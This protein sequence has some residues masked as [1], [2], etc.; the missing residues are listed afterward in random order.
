MAEQAKSNTGA[1]EDSRVQ[2][3]IAEF[4]SLLVPEETMDAYAV[5]RRIFALAHRRLLVCATSGR[6]IGMSRGL[7]GGFRPDTVRWQDIKD[8]NIRVGMLGA[9][10]TISALATPDLAVAGQTRVLSF[11]G[12][13]KNQAEAVYR[14]CQAQEQ[15]WREKRRVRELEELRA[16]SGGMQ[17]GT[18]TGEIIG[19]ARTVAGDS[20]AA[21]LAQAKQMF[22]QK[23]IT[24]SEYESL[25]ARIVGSL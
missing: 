24:D 20:A 12:L 22:D 8:V 9:D 17:L 1:G 21:R 19:A 16:K 7:F 10:L 2:R 23:L 4:Q 13:R 3:G 14:I 15:A 5:Q 6:F 18:P 11:P 25:K